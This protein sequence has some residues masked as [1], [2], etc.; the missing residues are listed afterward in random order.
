MLQSLRSLALLACVAAP[1]LAQVAI[2]PHASTYNGFTRGFNFAAQTNFNIVQLELPLDAFQAGDTASFA[3]RVNGTM[4]FFSAGTPG[5]SVACNVPVIV[6]DIVD[7]VGNWSPAAP[8]TFTAHNSY[9]N[10]APYATVIEGVPHTLYRQGVQNDIG[11]P[12]WVQGS[13]FLYTTAT[14]T[15]QIGRVIMYTSQGQTGTVFATSSSVGTGCVRKYASFY[16]NNTTGFDLSNTSLSLQ[17]IGTGYVALPGATPIAPQTSTPVVMG[18][19]VVVPFPLGWTFP[20]AGGSTGTLSVSSNGFIHLGTN[21]NAGCCAFAP[22]LFFNGGSPC[23]AAKWRDLNPSAGGT[24]QFDTDPAN[25]VAYV[26]FTGVP[27][28]GGTVG[29]DFQYVFNQNGSME[30][31]FGNCA[32]TAGATGFSPGL[33]NLDPGSI[34]ISA[35]PVIVTDATDVRPLALAAGSQRPIQNTSV[36]LTT[37]NLAPSTFFGAVLVGLSNPSLDLTPLGMSG[38]T[39]YSDGL[40]TLLY[41][42]AG[43]PS[44]ATNFAIPAA[45]GLHLY[46]QS[47]AYDPTSGLTTLGAIASNG[48]DMLIG[49]W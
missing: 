17:F 2:P 49:D 24:V 37:S 25:G 34:D 5:P 19:D 33:N 35:S 42:P 43:A 8:G 27:D 41:I 32:P 3:V 30:L 29:N 31:R 10:T 38:C 6:G 14:T 4:A 45:V 16:E 46:A 15:G 21:A 20:Y 13:Q 22:A 7:V 18:D 1:A 40:V 9:G 12:A 11:N 23:I 28:F 44:V 47:I 36:T 26:T 39:Q 48:V